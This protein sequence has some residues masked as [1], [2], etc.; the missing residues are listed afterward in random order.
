MG[1]SQLLKGVKALARNAGDAIMQIYESGDFEAEVKKEGDFV[2]PLT[3]A[4][5]VS[6]GIIVSG[7]KELSEFPVISEE[8]SHDAGD[9]DTF[10]LVDPIDGTKEFIKRNGEFTV[11]IG[12]VKNHKPV[13]GVVYAPAKEVVYYAT[14]EAGA[15]KQEEGKTPIKIT[16]E[17]KGKVP[18]VVASRSHMNE[19]TEAFLGKLGEHQT[20]S[21][22]SS[23]KLCLVAEGKASVYPRFTP[24]SLW[25]TAAAEAVVRA[26][27]GTVTDFR[28]KPL[29]YDPK[30]EILNPFF[31]VTAKG[32][33]YLNFI[34][35]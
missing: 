25:D 22:G 17:H 2:S 31:I 11:N 16:A 13:L 32:A 23:L 19:E 6:N 26:A 7:L 30:R 14:A 10:W 15:F 5:K 3:K 21:M 35:A 8:G 29:P 34:S 24:T 28:G 20:I 27:G 9:G 4:D 18:T 1:D 12:L 33:N